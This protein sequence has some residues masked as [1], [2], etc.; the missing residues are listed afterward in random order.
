MG[1]IGTVHLRL[2]HP[3]RPAEVQLLRAEVQVDGSSI[4][5]YIYSA[6]RWPF[7]IENNSDYSASFR[8]ACSETFRQDQGAASAPPSYT[9]A[10]GSRVAYAWDFPAREKM[11]EL[12]VNGAR[13]TLD[14]MEIGALMPFK[15]SVR[16][17]E[18]RPTIRPLMFHRSRAVNAPCRWTSVQKENSK[19]SGLRTTSRSAAST[20]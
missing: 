12:V 20:S 1:E 9:L 2:R 15:F 14:V 4:F 16:I 7:L 18:R 17:H 13:R 6:D 10:S 5:I 11:I 8:Q 19:F 3:D